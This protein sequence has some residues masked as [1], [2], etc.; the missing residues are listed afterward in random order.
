MALVRGD[1]LNLGYMML[2]DPTVPL[3]TMTMTSETDDLK[4]GSLLWLMFQEFLSKTVGSTVWEVEEC[5]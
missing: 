4:E 3:V 5:V 2:W 1:L